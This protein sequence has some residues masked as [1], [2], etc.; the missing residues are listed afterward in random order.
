VAGVALTAVDDLD[1]VKYR[2]GDGSW[3][4]MRPSGTEPVLRVYAEALQADMVQALLALGESACKY[5]EA[6]SFT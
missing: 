1:G 5:K 3:L 4:L 6:D 2:F